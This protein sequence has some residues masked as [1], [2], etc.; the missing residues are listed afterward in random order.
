MF[1]LSFVGFWTWAIIPKVILQ[2]SAPA[3]LQNKT[4]IM[5]GFEGIGLLL[6]FAAGAVS[7]SSLFWRRSSLSLPWRFVFGVTLA[8]FVIGTIVAIEIMQ[9]TPGISGYSDYA[10]FIV[11]T[12]FLLLPI[13]VL[14]RS[15]PDLAL[16]AWPTRS[17]Q[18]KTNEPPHAA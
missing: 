5:F 10:I 3:H 7:L 1:L 13:V 12:N 8:I 15:Y 4:T 16:T 11:S 18:S 9:P 2:F 14:G 6:A 17:A